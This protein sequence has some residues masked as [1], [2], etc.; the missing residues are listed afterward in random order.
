M[1]EDVDGLLTGIAD[2]DWC[3]NNITGGGTM[4]RF[5]VNRPD[6]RYVGKIHEHLVRK[7]RSGLHLTDVTKQ[8]AFLHTGYQEQEKKDKS[9]FERNLN[10]ILEILKQDPEN[11][12]YLGYLGDIFFQ[13]EKMKKQGIHRRWQP[14]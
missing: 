2:L 11:C 10:I 8:L 12:D 5:F 13:T 4:L 9:K 7:G 3:H 6:L 14:C 1:G